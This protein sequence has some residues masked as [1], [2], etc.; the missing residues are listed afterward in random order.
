MSD[1][2]IT[3]LVETIDRVGDGLPGLDVSADLTVRVAGHE[4]TVEAYTDRVFIDFPSVGAVVDVV[5]ATPG[6]GSGGG[7]TG[8]A[9]PAA[10]AAA[11]LTAVARVGSR[12]IA[13]LGA[14]ADGPLRHLGYD[15]VS[16]SVPNVLLGALGA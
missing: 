3:S 9:L 4:L 2:P 15:N 5:R 6:G 13:T 12:E 1:S 10:L 16:V 8:Q 14:E 7:S 11:D